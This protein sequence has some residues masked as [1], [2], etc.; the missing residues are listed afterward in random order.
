[1]IYGGNLFEIGKSHES[2]LYSGEY[3]DATTDL[4]YLRSRWYDPSVGRFKNEDTYEGELGNPL[5]LNL[6]RC[7]HNNMSNLVWTIRIVVLHSH[8]SPPLS[9]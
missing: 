8:G 2:I 1:M 6:Y 5:S 3:L 7:V 9:A 4:Q